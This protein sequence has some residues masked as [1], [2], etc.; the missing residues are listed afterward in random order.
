[1]GIVISKFE[2]LTRTLRMPIGIRTDLRVSWQTPFTSPGTVNIGQMI[3]VNTPEGAVHLEA[4]A[5]RF[6]KQRLNRWIG[7]VVRLNRTDKDLVT[8]VRSI[9]NALH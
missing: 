1:M 3:R 7:R 5:F 4:G 2:R 8:T 9:A 6:G